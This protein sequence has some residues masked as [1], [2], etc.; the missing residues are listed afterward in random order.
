[1]ARIQIRT[2]ISI[3]NSIMPSFITV[4]DISYFQNI[5]SLLK[6]VIDIISICRSIVRFIPIDVP[7]TK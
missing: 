2:C 4:I 3:V 1:M 5:C 7:Y 6:Y